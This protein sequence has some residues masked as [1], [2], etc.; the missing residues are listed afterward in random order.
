MHHAAKSKCEVSL[1][2]DRR[3]DLDHRQVGNRRERMWVQVES[4]GTASCP[5]QLNVLQVIT[6]ELA[7]AR[8]A[9]DVGDDLQ[10]K[11]SVRRGP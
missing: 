5:F 3:N 8:A 10:Q 7:D 11:V 1:D 9:I 4:R 6:D 2:V